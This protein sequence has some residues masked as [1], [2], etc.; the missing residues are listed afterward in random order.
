MMCRVMAT[1]SHVHQ[2]VDEDDEAW[3]EVQTFDYYAR[4]RSA[5]QRRRLWAKVGGRPDEWTDDEQH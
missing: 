4:H 5:E 3:T 1:R 2:T